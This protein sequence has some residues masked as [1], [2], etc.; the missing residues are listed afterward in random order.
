MA[1]RPT[2]R[3]PRRDRHALPEP[4]TAEVPIIAPD[5]HAAAV[6]LERITARFPALG[7]PARCHAALAADRTGFIRKYLTVDVGPDPP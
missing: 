5:E 3:S 1:I 6:L 2:G 7:E 4:G